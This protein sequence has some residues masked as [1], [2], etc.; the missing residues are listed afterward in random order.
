MTAIL[1]IENLSRSFDGVKA[2]AD[3]SI[4]LEV[5]KV[6]A[7]IGPNGS[8]KT[9]LFNVITGFLRPDSGRIYVGDRDVTRWPPHRIAQVGVGR[10]FQTLRLCGQMSVLENVM[11][12][13]RFP[14][15][16]R[17]D[18]ALLR[19]KSMLKEEEANRATAFEILKQVKMDHKAN[20]MG[21]GLS[22]GQRRL[23]E[24]G[25]A[26]ALEPHLLLLDEPMS[27]LWPSAIDDTK[28][29]IRGLAESGKTVLFIEHNIQ[30]VSDLA[31][32]V[33]VLNEGRKIAEGTPTEI[34]ENEEV[35]TAYLG[36]RTHGAA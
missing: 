18:L 13:L 1:R 34:R 4:S 21:A 27:G 14:L 6:T 10:T 12:A 30:V 22:H 26:L 2:V 35:L 8:G 19:S 16:E 17:L 20:A 15:G 33:I 11:L 36:K 7:L 3:L 9:T 5:G 29:I 28:D 25:R 32:H 24:I 23:L 31:E